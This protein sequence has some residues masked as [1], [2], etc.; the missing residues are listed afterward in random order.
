MSSAMVGSE[1]DSYVTTG[2]VHVHVL[3]GP[4]GSPRKKGAAAPF[5]EQHYDA[6]RG[7]SCALRARISLIFRPTSFFPPKAVP[8]F[9]PS[10]FLRAIA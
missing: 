5:A 3:A 7:Y 10:K 9:W 1:C 2:P 6:A 8:S 4:G